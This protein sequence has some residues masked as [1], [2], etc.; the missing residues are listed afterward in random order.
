MNSEKWYELIREIDNCFLALNG[1]NLPCPDDVTNRYEWL[2]E[3]ANYSI[4]AH[5]N[6]DDPVFIYANQYALACFKYSQEEILG[7][8]S[9]FSASASNR[10]LRE[11]LLKEVTQNGIAYNYSGERVDKFGN[12]FTISDGIIWQLKND[13]KKVW[14][15]AAIFWLK[16]EDL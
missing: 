2:H 7:L 6:G 16:K 15:Q 9:K 12:S 13:E 5:N 4:L 3:K 11:L 10:E 8:P 1:S 14:G